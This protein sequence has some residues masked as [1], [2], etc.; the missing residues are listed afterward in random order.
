VAVASTFCAAA[1]LFAPPELLELLELPVDDDWVE[2]ELPHAASVNAAT[3]NSATRAMIRAG[4]PR[5][6]M[7]EPPGLVRS[8]AETVSLVTIPVTNT[9]PRAGVSRIFE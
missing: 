4:L 1:R 8:R 9:P 2:L 3:T 5:W 6:D 7:D